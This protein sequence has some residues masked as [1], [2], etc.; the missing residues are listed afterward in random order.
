MVTRTG[1]LRRSLRRPIADVTSVTPKARCPAKL[2]VTINKPELRRPALGFQGADAT[3]IVA[4]NKGSAAATVPIGFSG[5][6]T[7]A[8]CTPNVTSATD[9]LKAATAVAVSGGSLNAVLP[10][11]SVTSFVGK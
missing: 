10:S 6:A 8:A 7:P 5:G 4:I 2:S 1:T 3:V 11:M 9:N